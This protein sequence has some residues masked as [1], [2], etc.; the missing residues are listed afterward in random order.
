MPNRSAS[1][2][3]GRGLLAFLVVVQILLLPV[4]YGILIMDR[5]AA[6]SCRCRQAIRLSDGDAA[7]LVWEGKDGVTFLVRHGT[8]GA[9]C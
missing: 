8:S 3:L 1:L 4:N 9:C 6:A 7:W 5:V 2:A